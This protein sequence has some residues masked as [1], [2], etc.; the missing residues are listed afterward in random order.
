MRIIGSAGIGWIVWV[1]MTGC[2][3]SH[4]DLGDVPREDARAPDDAGP[5]PGIPDDRGP[6]DDADD[7]REIPDAHDA[8]D[9]SDADIIDVPP[10]E[11]PPCEDDGLSACPNN[12]VGRP[13]G[14]PCLN[15]TDC[16]P[17]W[18]CWTEW[19][20]SS[21]RSVRRLGRRLLPGLGLRGCGLRS[22]RVGFVSPGIDRVHLG[23]DPGSGRRAFGC[24]D[25]S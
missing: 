14:G 25:S 5:D 15:D 12:P 20:M 6:R 3:Q 10:D 1:A 18:D 24:L 8:D 19:R 22:V 17:G 2:Y 9:R 7:G 13:V 11:W 16:D 21:T 23:E 4:S